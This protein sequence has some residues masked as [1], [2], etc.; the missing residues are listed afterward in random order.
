MSSQLTAPSN[1]LLSSSCQVKL[2]P[3]WAGLVRYSQSRQSAGPRRRCW[4]CEACGRRGVACCSGAGRRA[5]APSSHL[6]LWASGDV[7][8][9]CEDALETGQ[10]PAEGAAE[11]LTL[12]SSSSRS[13]KPSWPSMRLMH[14][15]LSLN[16]MVSQASSSLMYSSC[17][18]WNTC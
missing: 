13:N 9:T 5:S 8:E 14:C 6:N 17:S 2:R 11:P 4:T 3:L 7:R 12:H 1:S 18:S 15:W 10:L 16:A